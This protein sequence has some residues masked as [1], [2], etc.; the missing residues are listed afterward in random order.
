MRSGAFPNEAIPTD[1]ESI[2]Q[3]GRAA[4]RA[5]PKPNPARYPSWYLNPPEKSGFIYAV[6]EKTF[7]VSKNALTM[8]EVAAAANLSNQIM[9]QIQSS[10]SEVS[11]NAGTSIDDRTRSE[12]LRRLNYKVVEQI[13]NNETRTAY[14]LLEMEDPFK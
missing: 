5:S 11:T 7:D 4:V 6:G 12:A 13:Y 14:V 2:V 9:V 8:A 3:A 10:H 1:I